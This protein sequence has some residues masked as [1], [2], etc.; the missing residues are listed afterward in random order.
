MSVTGAQWAELTDAL[1]AQTEATTTALTTQA[2]AQL[3]LESL[4]VAGQSLGTC[5]GTDA[6]ALRE[7]LRILDLHHK[8]VDADDFTL[9]LCKENARGGL[10]AAL[11]TNTT[12]I[13]WD[14]LKASIV[15]NFLHTAED[16]HYLATLANVKQDMHE[17]EA[18]NISRFRTHT[19]RSYATGV[20]PGA[21]MVRV[22]T[23]FL[24]GLRDNALSRRTFHKT[25]NK[26]LEE[27]M[28]VA[29]TLANENYRFSTLVPPSR[30]YQAGA[31]TVSA[32]TSAQPA[33]RD[34]E[35]EALTLAVKRLTT[36]VGKLKAKDSPHGGTKKKATAYKSS[37]V[38][39]P[40]ITK[41]TTPGEHTKPSA[42]RQPPTGECFRCG[43]SGHRKV[44]CHA[45]YHINR[46]PICAECGQ[47]GHRTIDCGG[48]DRKKRK[49]TAAAAT[50]QSQN[51]SLNW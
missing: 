10:Q 19:E 29:Q 36:E 48:N 27:T 16:L 37:K 49:T 21:E 12:D 6:A 20:T 15:R 1:K 17:T 22:Q 50:N 30:E 18:A 33:T 51:N 44:D 11:F 26:T 4:R 3:R 39:Q 35:M 45:K 41:R 32:P 2:K 42:P 25:E 28:E 31:A 8:K 38:P 47:V 14:T 24:R 7:W 40:K 43:R 5:D 13:T 34:A 23:L 9:A 46:T